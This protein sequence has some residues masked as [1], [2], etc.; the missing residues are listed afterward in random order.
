MFIP[1]ETVVAVDAVL[2]FV[3][4]ETDDVTNVDPFLVF[5]GEAK[6][7]ENYIKH[8]YLYT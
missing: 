4:L 6:N 7:I 1:V 2:G 8:H 5:G 3:D